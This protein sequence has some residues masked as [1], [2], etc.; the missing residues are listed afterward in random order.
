[1]KCVITNGYMVS[2]SFVLFCVLLSFQIYTGRHRTSPVNVTQ[3]GIFSELMEEIHHVKN[4]INEI[5][6]KVIFIT[7]YKN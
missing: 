5:E 2:I 3:P 1:M 4:S 7:K 6:D